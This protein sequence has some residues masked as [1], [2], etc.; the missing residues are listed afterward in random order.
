MCESI[1]SN[2]CINSHCIEGDICSCFDGYDL[3]NSS[4]FYCD[5]TC[6]TPCGKFGK[7]VAPDTC[8]CDLGKFL[9][10]KFI[11]MLLLLFCFFSAKDTK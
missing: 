11:L 5:P 3:R 6:K 8:E 9:C 4:T 7:C 2:D 10:L 1:C